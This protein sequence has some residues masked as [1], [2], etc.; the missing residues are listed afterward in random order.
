MAFSKIQFIGNLGKDPETRYTPNGKSV[1]S[2][3]AA[4]SYSKPDGSGGWVD[5]GTDWF[6]VQIW[7][8]RGE[9]VAERIG[10]GSKVFVSGRFRSRE[11]DTKDGR[12]GVALDVS[13]DD[14]IDIS[15]KKVSDEQPAPS[16]RNNAADD[17][18]SD[19]L[20]F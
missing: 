12:H 1:T 13:A 20:P 2:F 6:N 10:K 4:V 16:S 15:G 14:V 11:Y 8:E 17:T 5:E 9:R 19:D 7:G 3:S 18:E